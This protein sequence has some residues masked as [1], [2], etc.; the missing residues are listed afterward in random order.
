LD[1][2]ED[3]R[4]DQDQDARGGRPDILQASH[5]EN[6]PVEHGQHANGSQ[7][8]D[9]ALLEDDVYVHQ[10]VAHD[11]IRPGDRD[12]REREHRRVH[13]RIGDS[14]HETVGNRVEDRERRGPQDRPHA[15]PFDLLPD[16]RILHTPVRAVEHPASEQIGGG[17]EHHRDAIQ[18]PVQLDRLDRY[19]QYPRAN[20]QH[21]R[22]HQDRRNVDHDDP[23]PLAE[24]SALLRE[25]QAEVQEDGRREQPG[26]HI[27]VVHGLVETVQLPCVVERGQDE[28]RQAEGIKVQRARRIPAPEEHEQPHSQVH[29]ADHVL[30]VQ[31][32]VVP[33]SCSDDE[34][35]FKLDALP[36]QHIR[37]LVPRAHADQNLADVDRPLDRVAGYLHDNVAAA[38]PNAIRGAPGSDVERLHRAA[39]VHPRD[40]IV[41]EFESALLLKVDERGHRRCHREDHQQRA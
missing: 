20:S 38:D 13:V 11:G 24:P 9:I 21:D 2:L 1:R 22:G 15:Q 34:R 19:T 28:R 23:R 12:Q 36:P 31:R 16:D 17:Q 40:T 32:R 7:R 3:E 26:Q 30:P 33:K 39:S 18:K 10:P 29:Q 35:R 25:H 4:R 8:V 6:Q 41:G 27:A 37:G 14:A 5:P